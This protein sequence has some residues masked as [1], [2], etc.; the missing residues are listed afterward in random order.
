MKK[1]KKYISIFYL[2]IKNNLIFRSN[3]TIHWMLQLVNLFVSLWMWNLL[4]DNSRYLNMT[5]YL[6]ITNLAALIFTTS[7]VFLLSNLI[8]TGKLTSYLVRPISAYRYIFMYSLGS[9]FPLILFY[10]GVFI[11]LTHE[12]IVVFVLIVYLFLAQLM[13]FNLMWIL[14]CLGFWLMNMWPLRNG[15]N[16][17]YLLLGGMYFPLSMFGENVYS[18]LKYNPF[19]LVTDIPA[20]FVTLNNLSEII[21]ASFTVVLWGILFWLLG[22]YLFKK[23]LN[24]YE[25]V[26]A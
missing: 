25:G 19:S 16:A 6:I 26:G 14:G 17:I 15:L 5:K 11:V 24:K 1:I 20:R 3:V 4:L 2:G 22:K 10:I 21:P 13:F 8:Q 7:P 18:W 9:Q 12:F 23:G